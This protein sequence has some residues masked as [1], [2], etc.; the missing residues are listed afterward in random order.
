MNILSQQRI[1]KTSIKTTK[2]IA[3][4]KKYSN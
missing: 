4:N 3:Y 1:I 2:T